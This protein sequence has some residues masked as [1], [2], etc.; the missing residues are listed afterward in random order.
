M[1]GKEIKKCMKVNGE[2]NSFDHSKGEDKY[3]ITREQDKL[4]DLKKTVHTQSEQPNGQE[5]HVEAMMM[6]GGQ[7]RLKNWERTDVKVFKW[8]LFSGCS[9]ENK[10][11]KNHL[12]G[13]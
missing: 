6:K 2:M 8:S 4:G 12:Q 3:H 5:T 13:K 9:D 10:R 11:I 1:S 7:K